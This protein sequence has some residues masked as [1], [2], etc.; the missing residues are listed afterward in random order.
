VIERFLDTEFILETLSSI[1]STLSPPTASNS[2]SLSFSSNNVGVR[3]SGFSD[4]TGTVYL[5]GSVGETLT[6][7]ANGELFSLEE[8]TSLTNVIIGGLANET[9][10]GK[11]EIFLT[12]PAGA[13]IETRTEI[14]TYKGRISNRKRSFRDIQQGLEVET[15]PILFTTF[16]SPVIAVK[17]YVRA[18]GRTF[19]VE[20]ISYPS[21][22]YGNVNHQECELREIPG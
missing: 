19:A 13:P 5:Q 15:A 20:T 14:G 17:D 16:P 12:T 10:V 18:V 6:F 9:T 4:G 21:D 22:L 11:I 3:L 7:P 1:L 2:V 8:F